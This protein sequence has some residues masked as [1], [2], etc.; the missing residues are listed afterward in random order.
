MTDTSILQLSN[1]EFDMGW[2]IKHTIIGGL[3]VAAVFAGA[4]MI[5]TVLTGSG[6]RG[7]TRGAARRSRF[8]PNWSKLNGSRVANQ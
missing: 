8:K 1:Q 4:E 3:I 2:I 6:G 7:F 5:L